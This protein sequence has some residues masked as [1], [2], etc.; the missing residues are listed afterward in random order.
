MRAARRI[1]AG[2][3]VL[4][5]LIAPSAASAAIANVQTGP[6]LT[7]TNRS[8]ALT[9]SSPSTAGTLLVAV[10]SNDKTSTQRAFT[11]P[12]GWTF[13]EQAYQAC[14]GEAEIWYYV[15]NPGGISSATFAA[16]TG[17]VMVGQL[18]EWSGVATS[19]P[20]DQTGTATSG[21]ASSLTVSTSANDTVAGDLGVTM[22]NAS[23][24]VTS[25]TPGTGWAHLFTDPPGAAVVSDYELGLASGAK[26]TE[27]EAAVGAPPSW[28]GDI[29]TFKPLACSGG[30]LTLGTPASLSFPAVTGNGSDQT[31]TATLPLTPSDMTNS[32]AGWNI[33]GTSTTFTAGTRKLS[34]SA[35]SITAASASLATG[36]CTLPTNA[37]TYPLTLPAGTTAPTAVKL[38][39]AATTTGNGPSNLNLT[40]QLSVPANA[41]VGAYSSTWTIA[42]VSGP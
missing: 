1:V 27:A 17:R 35:T 10:L 37:I 2:A 41:Y 34:T 42:I 11:G 4:G 5:A 18:T 7:S 14:C 9:L 3:V 25:F 15:N 30:S 21:A 32:G 28:L 38:F 40:T 33:T 24:A 22:F 19:A 36:T 8:L 12:A 29:V 6:Y 20:V 16:N 39:N 13:A 31:V 23:S 26:A